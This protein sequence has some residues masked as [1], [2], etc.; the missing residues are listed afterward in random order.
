MDLLSYQRQKINRNKLKKYLD[1]PQLN[2]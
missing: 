2:N 1:L